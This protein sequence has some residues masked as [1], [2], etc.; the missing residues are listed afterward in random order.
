MVEENVQAY[1]SGS[2][3]P[4]R[5]KLAEDR[6]R[7]VLNTRV[8]QRERAGARFEFGNPMKWGLAVRQARWRAKLGLCRP[9]P[10]I[11]VGIHLP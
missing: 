10:A 4:P 9:L 2:S 11:V 8:E 1:V 5:P 3:E 7:S 6:A